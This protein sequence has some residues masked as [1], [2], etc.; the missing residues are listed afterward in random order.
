MRRMIGIVMVMAL[1]AAG[2]TPALAQQKSTLDKIVPNK[3]N[4]TWVIG[5][6]EQEIKLVQ[7]PLS[8]FAKIEWFGLLGDTLNRAAQYGGM[9]LSSIITSPERRENLLSMTDVQDAE[10]FLQI[11][12]RLVGAAPEFLLE[13]YCIWLGVPRGSRTYAKAIMMLPEEE[14]G[15]SDEAGLMVAQTFLDQNAEALRDFILKRVPTLGRRAMKLMQTEEK[16]TE[17][18]YP[19]TKSA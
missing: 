15:F 12:L 19:D 9:N 4:K 16:T 8:Y 17:P 18:E 14:G 3:D 13:S 1:L 2:M 5:A 11:I 6:G 7:K 10:T